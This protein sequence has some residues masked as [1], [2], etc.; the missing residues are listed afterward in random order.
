MPPIPTL[1]RLQ[2]QRQEQVDFVDHLLS[3]V[4]AGEGR[5]LVPAERANLD[6]ARQRLAELDEQI[7]PLAEFEAMR[8]SA[9]LPAGPRG[10]GRVRP[11][12]GPSNQLPVYSSAG[13]FIIDYLSTLSHKNGELA[14]IFGERADAAT[15]RVRAMREADA[16]QRA[17]N[18]ITTDTPGILPVPVVGPVLNTID[19]SRPL[20][21]SLGPKSLTGIPGTQFS[22]PHI[23]QHA[24]AGKQSAEKTALP[25]QPMKID[26]IQFAKETFGGS[27]NISR[28]D[29]DWTS[30]TAWDILVQDLADAYAVATE[31]AT[32]AKFAA[33]ANMNG[34]ITVASND[35]A[36]WAAALYEA[37]ALVYQGC[38]RLPD[39]LWVALDVWSK[40]GPVV[41]TAKLV[42]PGA[43][44]GG[45]GESS[46]R[47]FEGN[48]FELDRVVVPSLPDGTAIVGSSAMAEFYEERIGLLSAVEPSI[49]GVE[50]AYGGYTAFGF[51]EQDGFTKLTAPTVPLTTTRSTSKSTSSAS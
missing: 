16:F 10:S 44:D 7:K 30:P 36:G 1:D 19:A 35:L 11:V 47:R 12:G 38:G 14:N 33:A 2:E 3:Q 6:A 22:R 28:Q 43:A 20:I 29:I 25:S 8:E 21:T 49:L 4:D 50:V 34:P 31:E 26:P 51:L 46:L 24:T 23:T 17:A 42:F 48:M 32:T 45:S 40:V 13:T 41:D 18:Q 27:V 9:V 15:A 39:R 37:A 5:D